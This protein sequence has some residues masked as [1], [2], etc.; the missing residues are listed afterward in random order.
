[1]QVNPISNYNAQTPQ[2]KARIPNTVGKR[3]ADAL[4]KEFLASGD[5]TKIKFANHYLDAIKKLKKNKEIEE[6]LIVSTDKTY[7][8]SIIYDGLEKNCCGFSI[9]PI[10]EELVT[11]EYEKA[12]IFDIMEAISYDAYSI[13]WIISRIKNRG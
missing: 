6:I 8:P 2:F 11:K 1:M 12:R 3:S 5:K 9:S 7:S 10:R 13:E 4:A